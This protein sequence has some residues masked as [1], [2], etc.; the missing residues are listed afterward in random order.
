MPVQDDGIVRALKTLDVRWLP[1]SAYCPILLAP[2]VDPVVAADG[3]SY[4]RAAIV[5]W[6][7][8]KPVSPVTGAKLV[9]VCVVPNHALR[10]VIGDLVASA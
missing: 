10:N 2:M 3:H 8:V 9:H 4:E 7:K 5:R 1:Q 6:L